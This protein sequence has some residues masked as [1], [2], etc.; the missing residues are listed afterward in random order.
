MFEV[1]EEPD[2]GRDQVLRH[3]KLYVPFLDEVQKRAAEAAGV[4]EVSMIE[5]SM[6][7]LRA[8]VAPRAT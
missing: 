2:R 4:H 1:P 3:R 6:V 8:R 7:N 5:P